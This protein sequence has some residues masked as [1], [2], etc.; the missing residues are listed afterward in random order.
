LSLPTFPEQA[1][2]SKSPVHS[3]HGGEHAKYLSE[4]AREM[5]LV[6]NY[7][8]DLSFKVFQR[9]RRSS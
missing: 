5:N 9:E 8:N 4:L 2:I 6:W 3:S 1:F 7:V